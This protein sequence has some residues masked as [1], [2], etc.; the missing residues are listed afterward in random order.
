MMKP[1]AVLLT[2]KLFAKIGIAGTMSPYPT[3]TKKPTTEST[4][5]SLGS[6]SLVLL[7]SDKGVINQVPR[8][9]RLL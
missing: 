5:T 4:K 6:L 1:M 2:P 7:F 3:A 8:R 9:S